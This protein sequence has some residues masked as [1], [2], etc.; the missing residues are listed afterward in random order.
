MGEGCTVLS[1]I[2]FRII[3]ARELGQGAAGA[4][5]FAITLMQATALGGME[6]LS[7]AGTCLQTYLDLAP[8]AV[9]AGA[10]DM[11]GGRHGG[12]RGRSRQSDRVGEN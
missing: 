12:A 2:G 9:Q 8:P 11:L 1:Q 6:V 10:G 3:H 4:L 5:F 7:T